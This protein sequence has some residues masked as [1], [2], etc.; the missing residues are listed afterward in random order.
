MASLEVLAYTFGVLAVVLFGAGACAFAVYREMKQG[1]PD[2]PDFFLT[3][4]K[5]MS[6]LTIAWSFYAG[7]MGSWALF[8]PPSYCAYAGTL[9]MIMYSI[10]AGL[11]IIVVAYFGAVIHRLVPSVVSMADYVRRRFGLGVHGGRE[12]LHGHHRLQEPAHHPR[13]RPRLAHLHRYWRAL[14]V[15]YYR[16]VAGGH[17]SGV[18]AGALHIRLRHHC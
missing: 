3:A 11:P 2:T 12:S 5:S 10:S 7:A 18:R 4:R 6:M 1:G 13:Y 15:H 8:G 16:P 14:R 9:G 17:I